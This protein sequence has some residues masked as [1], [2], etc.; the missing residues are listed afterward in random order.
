MKIT[1]ET[2]K[3][4]WVTMPRYTHCLPA[5][6]LISYTG[7]HLLTPRVF[8]QFHRAPTMTLAEFADREMAEVSES[9]RVWE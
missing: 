4:Q 6:T 9:D 3:A 8:R 7:M 5:L 2:V 1:R